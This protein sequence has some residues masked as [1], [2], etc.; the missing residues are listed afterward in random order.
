VNYAK[1]GLVPINL[2]REKV[3]I[4]AGT[5][6]CKILSMPFTYLGLPMG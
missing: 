4:M 5:L 1:S 3:D 6:G 2:T